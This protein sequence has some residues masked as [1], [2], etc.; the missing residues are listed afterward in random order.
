[1]RRFLDA[2][3]REWEVTVGKESWGTLVLLFSPV[4]GDAVRKVVIAAE[5][6]LAAHAEL[7]ARSDETLRTQLASAS[8][9]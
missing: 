2:D 7:D 6:L 1:M 4:A 9:W 3:G 5:T 8:P